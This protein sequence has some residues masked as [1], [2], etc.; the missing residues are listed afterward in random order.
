MRGST[1]PAQLRVDL[2]A[3]GN[4]ASCV[5]QLRRS[6][7]RIGFDKHWSGPAPVFPFSLTKWWFCDLVAPSEQCGRRRRA[8]AAPHGGRCSTTTASADS[9]HSCRQQTQRCPDVNQMRPSQTNV[10]R[11]STFDA[12]CPLCFGFSHRGESVCRNRILC[13]PGCRKKRTFCSPNHKNSQVLSRHSHANT[14]LSARWVGG[15]G[16]CH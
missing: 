3:V 12:G 6:V 9:Y 14:C 10:P 15:G 13:L 16:G 7:F 2:L 11:V 4:F 8:C 5:Q 1:R